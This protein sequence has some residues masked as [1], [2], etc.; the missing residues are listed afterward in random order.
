MLALAAMAVFA[1]WSLI[2]N[3]VRT[4]VLFGLILTAVQLP[5]SIL[6]ITLV[7]NVPGEWDAKKID[8]ERYGG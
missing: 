6:L 2:S 7:M 1:L 5:F 8:R 3:I 4:D